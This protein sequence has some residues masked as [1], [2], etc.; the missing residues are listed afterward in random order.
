MFLSPRISLLRLACVLVVAIATVAA[1]AGPPRAEEAVLRSNG[2]VPSEAVVA[3][4]QGDDPNV[5]QVDDG[6]FETSF[7]VV[8]QNQTLGSQGYFLN[9]FTVPQERLPFTIDSVSI[10]FPVT[11]S[12][13]HGGEQFDVLVFD[14][15]SGTSDASGTTLRARKS[16]LV[17]PSNTTFQLIQL[18]LPVVVLNGDVWVG[19]TNTSTRNDAR[20]IFPAAADTNSDQARSWIFFNNQVDNHFDGPLTTADVGTI[21][22]QGNWL[23]RANGQPG[24]LTCV[25]WDPPGSLRGEDTPPPVN[26]HICDDVPEPRPAGLRGPRAT[27]IGYN[28]Y[29]SD[30]P[31]VQPTPSNLFTS[32]PPTQ[33]MTG[34]SVSPSGSFFV[35]TGVYDTGE[36]EPSNELGVVPPQITKLAVKATKIQAKG[37]GFTTDQVQVFV[38]GL[39]FLSP[40]VVKAAGKKVVQKGN[41]ITGET[42][43]QYLAAHGGRAR[44]SFRNSTGAIRALD[45]PGN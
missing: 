19:F 10:L 42:I 44:I 18:D 32:V 37:T 21:I 43:G 17:H 40:A 39:P 6:S 16:F 13:L 12:N 22:H 15:P 5:L 45:H 26:T 14:G 38:D 7:G 20:P 29:R 28:V 23:I 36:S 8:N 34:S 4:V 1:S 11:N 3:G 31:N 24:G 35:V 25:T 33:T 2:F 41:L 30:Q 9:R 27:L